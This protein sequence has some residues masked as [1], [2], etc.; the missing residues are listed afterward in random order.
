[1]A[2]LTGPNLLSSGARLIGRTV[3]ASLKNESIIKNTLT[4]FNTPQ[5]EPA[6]QASIITGDTPKQLLNSFDDVTPI[7]EPKLE[8]REFK[9]QKIQ[10]G[11]LIK[12]LESI[13]D[14]ITVY[15]NT[16]NKNTVATFEF[17]RGFVHQQTSQLAGLK[18]DMGAV[19]REQ[20]QLTEMYLKFDYRLR[21]L[22]HKTVQ[23]IDEPTPVGPTRPSSGG[24]VGALLGSFG[25][26]IVKGTAAGAVAGAAGAAGARAGTSLLGR[27]LPGG[28]LPL[29]AEGL[30]LLKSQNPYKHRQGSDKKIS[31]E[32]WEKMNP[33]ERSKAWETFGNENLVDT[34]KDKGYSEK[35]IDRLKAMTPYER[36]IESFNPPKEQTKSFGHDPGPDTSETKSFGKGDEF[37]GIQVLPESPSESGS[38]PGKKATRKNILKEHFDATPLASPVSYRPYDDTQSN[39][40]SQVEAQLQGS[41]QKYELKRSDILLEASSDINLTALREIRQKAKTIT[42]EADRLVFDSDDITFTSAPHFKQSD[43]QEDIRKASY[44]PSQVD[45]GGSSQVDSESKLPG[46][47]TSPGGMGESPQ[48]RGSGTSSPPV[49]N[50]GSNEVG[51]PT[52]SFGNQPGLPTD[53]FSPGPAT[54]QPQSG[55]NRSEFEKAFKGT[56]LAGKYDIV[57]AEAKKNGISSALMA[58]IMG[59]E[60]GYGRNL[61][62]N[63]PGGIMDHSKKKQFGSLDEGIAKTA[64]TIAKNFKAGGGTI[65]GL[66]EKYAPIGAANDPN[67]LNK[68]WVPGVQ[69]GMKRFGTES[70]DDSSITIAKTRQASGDVDASLFNPNP[71]KLSEIIKDPSAYTSAALDRALQLENLHERRDRDTIAQY[72]KKGGAGMDPATTQWCAAFVNS[73]LQQEGIKGTGSQIATSFGGW[74]NSVSDASKVAKGDVAVLM[75]NHRVGETGGHVGFATGETKMVR[76]RDGKERLQVQILSGNDGDVVKRS[77]RDADELTIRR[78]PIE[79][80]SKL[81]GPFPKSDPAQKFIPNPNA[82]DPNDF[83]PTLKE[84]APKEDPQIDTKEKLEKRATNNRALF[85]DPATRLSQKDMKFKSVIG[86]GIPEGQLDFAK[87]WHSDATKQ[88]KAIEKEIEGSIQ[89]YN[90]WQSGIAETGGY[91]RSPQNINSTDQVRRLRGVSEDI[92]VR[93]NEADIIKSKV[94][95]DE[96]PEPTAKARSSDNDIPRTSHHPEKESGRPGSPGG[97]GGAESD[98]DFISI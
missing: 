38:Q 80:K 74:G 26:S 39:T 41:T 77:W 34:L 23:Q 92:D 52:K 17:I 79:E 57:V 71:T 22:E 91:S 45:P 11:N 93:S 1:M 94:I 76:G 27:V 4:P 15:M 37:E 46:V 95:P 44:N 54:P 32:Q 67:N 40:D 50:N 56:K 75:R 90:E 16:I 86:E 63:N 89:N 48:S 10:S 5:G 24:L 36:M 33:A 81:A 18:K 70:K 12:S 62:G 47:G 59:H 49:Q 64:E 14:G 29:A 30:S 51:P 9:A 61:N 69:S 21:N 66:G 8:T 3:M 25:G 97:R 84:D 96:T 7:K 13:H 53:K 55:L 98:P 2:E 42:F 82:P 58:S 20:R 88:L 43:R 68:S 28:S 31:D 6:S 72:L 85:G 60:S 87:P 35:Y 19:R 78:A 73:T 83:A 65:E